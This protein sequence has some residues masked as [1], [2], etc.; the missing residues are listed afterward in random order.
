[1]D[2]KFTLE[3]LQ[4]LSSGEGVK[5]NVNQLSKKFNHHRH[6]IKERLDN[7][8]KNN[9]IQ[10]PYYP[11]NGLFNEYNLFVISKDEFQ[12]DKKTESFI[13]SDPHFLAAFFYKDEV[14]NTVTIQIHKNLFSYQT[15]NEDVY[16]NRI[17]RHPGQHFPQALLLSTQ[18]ML[19]YDH[20][21]PVKVL[22]QEFDKDNLKRI[23]H[24]LIDD[25]SFDILECLVKGEC[26]RTNEN[27]LA[28]KLNASRKKVSRK[29]KALIES[30]IISYPRVSF[31]N[32]FAPPDFIVVLSLVE[33]RNFDAILPTLITDPHTTVLIRAN[34]GRYTLF[35][36][37][38]FPSFE[39]FLEWQEK[40]C[41]DHFNVIGACKNTFISPK[42]SYH[43]KWRAITQKYL[44]DRL[45]SL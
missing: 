36:V 3:L 25:L 31:I 6:T 13:N 18:R 24:S 23:N 45:K 4:C 17:T 42:L 33:I 39:S 26:I 2:D 38:T 16:Q 10:P 11:F 14:Y 44:S 9:I 37:S 8:I 20:T 43:V 21:A 7:L 27:Y 28:K 1:M 41:R 34:E 19:K 22:R 15:W 30:N 29:I 12:R 35:M 5:F 40:M 32:L